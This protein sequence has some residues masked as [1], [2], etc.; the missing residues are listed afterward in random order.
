MRPRREVTITTFPMPHLQLGDIVT[1]E[2]TMPDG[3]E[4]VD[5]TTRFIINDITYSR[6]TEG[7]NQIIKVV[8]V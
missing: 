1:I 4:Y 8:Q 6:T 7:P 3:V 2:Y 5:S